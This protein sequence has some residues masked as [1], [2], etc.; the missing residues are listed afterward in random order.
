MSRVSRKCV[1]Y[2]VCSSASVKARRARSL[3]A[4]SACSGTTPFPQDRTRS[5]H[6][7]QST[8]SGVPSAIRRI[9]GSTGQRSGRTAATRSHPS[10]SSFPGGHAW[11]GHPSQRTRDPVATSRGSVLP[12]SPCSSRRSPSGWATPRDPLRGCARP[13]C[14]RGPPCGD[15]ARMASPTSEPDPAG[16]ARPRAS[17]RLFVP[18]RPGP[19]GSPWATPLAL[20][21]SRGSVDPPRA[22]SPLPSS[23][24]PLPCL[25][26]RASAASPAAGRSRP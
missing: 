23:C 25:R 7:S 18:S 22:P 17:S 26:R 15:P 1:A 19:A 10:T 9:L 2:F 24:S 14:A 6:G 5:A 13:S 8:R 4:F 21:G 11:G 3:M 16:A 20:L 12:C